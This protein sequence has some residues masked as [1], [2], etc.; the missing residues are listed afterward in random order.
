MLIWLVV[1]ALLLY[2]PFNLQR[3]T[4][5]G[6]IIPIVYFGVRSLEDYW[7]G[8][9]SV[10]WRDAALVTLLVFIVP[11]NVLSYGLPLVGILDTRQGIAGGLLLPSGYQQAIHWLEKNAAPDQVVLAAPSPSLWI[12]A[13]T[14]LR[15]VYGHPF[16]TIDAEKKLQEVNGWYEGEDCQGVIRRYNVRYILTKAPAPGEVEPAW[17]AICLKTLG[18]DQPL[19]Q[20]DN[21]SIYK[22]P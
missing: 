21:V 2:A 14:A 1:N 4:V 5:I 10:K 12:P 13:Y 19:Q 3:R 20:F 22:A 9:I 17:P 7:F 8:R 16:E 6:M 18:L 15:V 11:S